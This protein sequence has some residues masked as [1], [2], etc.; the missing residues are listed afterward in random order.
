M[1]NSTIL[2]FKNELVFWKKKIVFVN[3]QTDPRLQ[4]LS[5]WEANLQPLG[6]MLR[7]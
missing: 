6:L 3:V 5:T 2:I 7:Q 4:Y 1:E